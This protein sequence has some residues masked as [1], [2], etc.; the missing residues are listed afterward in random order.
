MA[1]QLDE[2][3]WVFD[4]PLRIGPVNVGTRMTAVR[5]PD[6]GIFLHS[7]VELDE[8]T[9]EEIDALGPVRHVVAPNCFH[10]LFAA[11]YREAYGE[12]LLWAAPGLDEKRGDVGFDGV[13]GDEPNT[14]WAGS[15]SQRLFRGAPRVNEVV[16]F[17][18]ESRS[19]LL[20]DLAMNFAAGEGL[21]TGL[22]LR[23][24]GIRDRFGTSRLIR[25]LVR[26]REAARQSLDAILAWDFERVIVSHGVVLQRH[27]K[28]LLREA[29]AWLDTP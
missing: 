23:A 22:W 24:M 9:R 19:L 20:T 5:L 2:N 10:H 26:D 6:G 17:H 13:L 1:R 29:F 27:G 12:A 4:R 8:H 15:L 21:L 14:A 3:L 18:P 25:F 7:P 11:A 16:F 28:R